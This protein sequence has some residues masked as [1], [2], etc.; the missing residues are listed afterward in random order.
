VKTDSVTFSVV[1]ATLKRPDR[2]R[3]A[4]MS[5]ADLDH[6]PHEVLVVDGDPSRSADRAVSELGQL[7]FTVSVIESMAGAAY[8]RNR[9]IEQV[10]AGVVVFLDDDA[11]VEPGTL[12]ALAKA[13]AD[14]SVV[15]ATGRV[16]EPSSHRIGGQRSKLRRLLH[17]R[18]REGRFT[19]YGYPRR[20]TSADVCIDVE[21][22][23]GCF[24]S[25]RTRAARQVM[26]DEELKGYALAEDED[27][28][29][30][31][32]RLGR[33]RYVPDAVVNHDNS[34]FRQRD[35]RAFGRKVVINRAY[36]FRKNFQQTP[37]S[38][39][40]FWCFLVAMAIHRLVNADLAGV[41]GMVEGT[42]AVHRGVTPGTA[43]P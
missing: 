30:R 23:Q 38:R 5:L 32:S 13:Y 24:M 29:F 25:A 22:M 26:F 20:I 15:G 37:A 43:E 8:Q 16:D 17:A 28:S 14:D 3:S 7:P 36:L 1:V 21:F 40:R 42:T 2:L 41:R 4:L 6:L 19:S 12:S 11:R 34:G 35:R 39:V 10:K 27:F 31:L 9:G 33:I 18:S